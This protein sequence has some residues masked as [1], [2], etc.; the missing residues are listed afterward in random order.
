MTYDMLNSGGQATH[1]AD[2]RKTHRIIAP[3][4]NGKAHDHRTTASGTKVISF[5]IQVSNGNVT[6]SKARKSR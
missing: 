3:Q 5:Q 4:A 2:Q 1:P 6:V